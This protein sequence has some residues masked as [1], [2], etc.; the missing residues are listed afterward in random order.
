[1]ADGA[2][3]F[4]SAAWKKDSGFHFVIRPFSNCSIDHC[5]PLG[6]ILGMNTL[7]PFFPSR[8]AL[9]RI[10]AIY[11]MPFLREMCGLSPRHTPGPTPSVREPLRFR[12]IRLA[13]LQLL[14]LYFQGTCS[15]SL[16][17]PGRQQSQPEYD[18]GDGGNSGSAE[19]GDSYGMK[20]VR[21]LA[22]GAET[23]SGHGGVKH[24]GE[25]SRHRRAPGQLLPPPP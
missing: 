16:I 3:V 20:A 21:R 13:L 23:G 1:M 7:H 8:H 4:D 12:Q 10:E 25:F 14:F 2:D 5:L 6:T 9:V 17:D 24:D 18:K 22:G 11:A 19:R 15:A